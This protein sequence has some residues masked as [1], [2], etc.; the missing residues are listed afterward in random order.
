MLTA[1]PRLIDLSTFAGLL[2]GNHQLACF[3]PGCPRWAS[4]DLAMLVRNGLGGRRITECRPRCR[5]MRS[6]PRLASEAAGAD[7]RNVRTELVG[8]RRTIGRYVRTFEQRGGLAVD[9]GSRGNSRRFARLCVVAHTGVARPQER[10]AGYLRGINAELKYAAKHARIYVEGENGLRVLA[11][12]YR[13]LTRFG[14]EGSTWPTAEGFLTQA[15]IE[16]LLAHNAAA[17]EFNRRL[18]EVAD[19]ATR[20][21]RPDFLA[22]VDA[23]KRAPEKARNICTGDPPR[24]TANDAQKAIRTAAGRAGLI[25]AD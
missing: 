24:G 4:C 19:V 13:L 6:T 8:L 25:L 3:Y 15:D 11:P 7:A 23:V 9:S 18:D 14:V 1:M 22:R 2:R 17:E 21:T 12:A 16:A 5:E 20:E 10:A